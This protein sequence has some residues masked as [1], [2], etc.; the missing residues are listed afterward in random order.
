MVVSVSAMAE[1]G[2]CVTAMRQLGLNP[3]R[4]AL[5][6]YA[7]IQKYFQTATDPAQFQ[8]ETGFTVKRDAKTGEATE[9]TIRVLTDNPGSHIQ[10]IGDFN[11]WGHGQPPVELHVDPT[12]TAYHTGVI[13]GLKHGM[14]YRLVENGEE[15]IDPSAKQFTTPE[16]MARFHPGEQPFLNSIFWDIDHPGAYQ[17]KHQPPD[18][19]G[20]P[21][22][23]TEQGVAELVQKFRAADGQVGPRS[24]AE[25]YSFTA[26][27]GVAKEVAKGYNLFEAL[28]MGEFVDGGV[29]CF[30]YL[31]YGNFGP[32]SRYGTP[33][34]FREMVDAFNAAGVGVI[35]DIVPGH[36]PHS[37]NLGYRELEPVGMH[38]WRN[39]WG[40][41]LYGD[42]GTEWGTNRYD[43]LN[44]FVRRF[45]IDGIVTMMR[46]YRL[47]GIRIDN[48]DGIRSQPGGEIF[49][50][51][52]A[53]TIR[54]YFPSAYING[55]AFSDHSP[56]ITRTDWNGMGMDTTNDADFGFLYTGFIRTSFQK[57]TEELD[58]NQLRDILDNED[59]WQMTPRLRMITDHDEASQGSQGATGSYPATLVQGG[60]WYYVVNKIKA[61]NSLSFLSGPFAM[62]MLQTRI[63]QEGSYFSNPPVDWTLLERE[64]NRQTQDYFNS[65]FQTIKDQ[66]AFGMQ[67]HS[68]HVVNDFDNTNKVITFEKIDYDTGKRFFVVIN[69]GHRGMDNYRFG[70]QGEG[71]FRVLVDSDRHEFGGSNRLKDLLPGDVL[72]T[73]GQGLHDKDHSIV[74]PHLAP[75][76][77][78]ILEQQ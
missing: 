46:D 25:T 65:V 52:M 8:A 23:I 72:S 66:T 13:P 21:H 76:G 50:R 19:R 15:R 47:S 53:E 78:L 29:W 31:L 42:R 34:E 32:T 20:K 36:Y 70:A 74:L 58:M 59:T 18:L 71:T 41:S 14:Q 6:R 48:V 45:L 38:K 75:Y 30:H 24:V 2:A 33:D 68:P 27:S 4:G 22:W 69:L 7:A 10:V 64:S 49:L 40:A 12:N 9:V 51:E 17:M 56:A 73:D 5:W 26:R 28:P 43:Y 11:N 63:L 55:E 77:V 37:G 16:F 61:F 67:N 3:N 60:G 39:R 35:M 44:P 54:K 57:R 1:S 62:D